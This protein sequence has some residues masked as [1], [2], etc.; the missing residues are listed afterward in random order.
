LLGSATVDWRSDTVVYDD[1]RTRVDAV[2]LGV[3][4]D[5]IRDTTAETDGSFWARFRT[6]HDIDTS[7]T[8][9][10]GV[11]RLDYTKGIPERLEALERLFERRPDLRGELTYV[12]KGCVTRERIPAYQQLRSDVEDRIRALNGRFGTRDWSPVVYTTDMFDREN[13]FSLYQHSDLALVTPLR[14]GMNLVAKEYVAAQVDGDG[15]LLLSPY[16]G[17]YDQLGSAAIEFDPYDTAGAVDAVERALEMDGDER[18]RRMRELRR[19]VHETSLSWWLDE[20]IETAI[21]VQNAG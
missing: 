7:T 2:P 11:D 14:D 13:L 1:H 16:A 4:A 5:D 20:V 6:D 19:V 21:D 8:I 9:A 18:R 10:I 12:Q 3:D 15:M 17:A